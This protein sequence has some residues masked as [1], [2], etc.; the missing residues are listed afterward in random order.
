MLLTMKYVG[1]KGYLSEKCQ[2]IVK[3]IVLQPDLAHS[4]CLL[5]FNTIFTA[6]K[7]QTCSSCFQELLLSMLF[8]YNF[9]VKQGCWLHLEPK[10]RAW[11][12]KK[13]EPLSFLT[14]PIPPFLSSTSSWHAY[15]C[16]QNVVSHPPAG[17]PSR[18]PSSSGLAKLLL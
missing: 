12:F 1:K 14:A 5:T 4:D 2:G 8:Y 16:R 6:C 10:Q 15:P 9:G 7:P 11:F 18:R 17:I 3:E 13:F